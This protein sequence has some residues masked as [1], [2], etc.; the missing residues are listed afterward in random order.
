MAGANGCT[1]LHEEPPREG[2]SPK[3]FSAEAV[4]LRPRENRKMLI[5][6]S[7][8]LVGLFAGSLLILASGIH[9]SKI[10]DAVTQKN[11]DVSN[12]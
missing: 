11:T 3:V 4:K 7:G 6:W 5:C 2:P 10:K 8:Q 12:R 9:L 1:R